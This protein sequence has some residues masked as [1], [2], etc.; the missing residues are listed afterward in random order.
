MS[1]LDRLTP[2]NPDREEEPDPD[3]VVVADVNEAGEVV[4]AQA[5]AAVHGIDTRDLQGLLASALEAARSARGSVLVWVREGETTEGFIATTSGQLLAAA[6]S[7]TPSVRID[8]ARDRDEPAKDRRYCE[9]TDSGVDERAIKT[10]HPP[11]E[12]LAEDG[13]RPRPSQ[14]LPMS[15]PGSRT[16]L[17]NRK[18]S[19]PRRTSDGALSR[20]PKRWRDTGPWLRPAVG[21][22]AHELTVLSVKVSSS[23]PGTVTFSAHVFSSGGTWVNL[24]ATVGARSVRLRRSGG[25]YTGTAT[26]VGAGGQS[27]TVSTGSLSA[28]GSVTVY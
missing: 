21:A 13:M 11:V 12:P 28:S 17:R 22:W 5:G 3:F 25:T 16:R 4:S 6:T 2:A 1:L 9:G 27:W 19:S 23:S 8:R 7:L 14:L 18:R 26:G 20:S 10:L 24:A 15:R